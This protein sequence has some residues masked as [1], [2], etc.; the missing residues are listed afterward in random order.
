MSNVITMNNM[1]SGTSSF[2]QDVRQWN[3]SSVSDMSFMFCE[4]SSFNKVVICDVCFLFLFFSS[5][6]GQG[7]VSQ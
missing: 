3:A 2:N 5:L 1:F 7:H 4:A 6:R